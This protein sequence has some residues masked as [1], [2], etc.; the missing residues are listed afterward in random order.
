[1]TELIAGALAMGYWTVAL[2]FLRYWT[3]THDRLFATFSAAF[4]I[5]GCVRIA[6]IVA[7]DTTEHQ[8]LYWFRLVA[9]LLILFAVID[10][11]RS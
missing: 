5:L 10:K 8:Y 4:F 11:N 7:A 6:L 9:Y 1:M 3:R 2:F